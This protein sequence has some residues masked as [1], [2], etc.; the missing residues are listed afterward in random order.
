MHPVFFPILYKGWQNKPYNIFPLLKCIRGC[1]TWFLALAL[2]LMG[3]LLQR[4]G[5]LQGGHS[6]GKLVDVHLGMEVLEWLVPNC[7][8]TTITDRWTKFKEG[9]ICMPYHP[10]PSQTSPTLQWRGGA[11]TF[12]SSDMQEYYLENMQG[13]F[14]RFP[15]WH[16][17][18]TD[19]FAFI[20]LWVEVYCSSP[21]PHVKES[22][23]HASC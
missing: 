17:W 22:Y 8:A 10:I 23:A 16:P 19:F 3:A 21:Q 7:I 15:W 5:S 11:Y 18:F 13:I 2:G 6:E 9:S 14:P 12:A 4:M 20:S 1:C